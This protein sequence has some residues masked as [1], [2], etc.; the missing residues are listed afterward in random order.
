MKTN[1]RNNN[2]QSASLVLYLVERNI[3]FNKL[4]NLK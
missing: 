1:K 4:I 3:Y 2:Y